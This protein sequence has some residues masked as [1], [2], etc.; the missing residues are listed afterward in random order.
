MFGE[1]PADRTS[2]WPCATLMLDVFVERQ[3]TTHDTKVRKTTQR[4]RGG[5]RDST[6]FDRPQTRRPGSPGKRPQQLED[7]RKRRNEST[8]SRARAHSRGPARWP[9]R[10]CRSGAS[11]APASPCKGARARPPG[12]PPRHGRS[13][14]RRRTCSLGCVWGPKPRLGTLTKRLHVFASPLSTQDIRERTHA[15]K[16][17]CMYVQI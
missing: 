13:G 2:D 7:N 5:T 3:T 11:S 6:Y 16:H 15:H 4:R 14:N 1:T 8:S 17:A 12:G 10:C 9:V